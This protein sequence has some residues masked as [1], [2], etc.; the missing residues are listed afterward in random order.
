MNLRFAIAM[1]TVSFCNATHAMD[2]DDSKS[3]SFHS[4]LT[5]GLKRDSKL[6]EYPAQIRALDQLTLDR[7]TDP[8]DRGCIRFFR[9]NI[10][11]QISLLSQK[12]IEVAPM[13]RQARMAAI[14]LELATPRK[15]Y[16]DVVSF[17]HDVVTQNDPSLG[18]IPVE[19][20]LAALTESHEFLQKAP[21]QDQ[22]VML[23]TVHGTLAGNAQSAEEALPHWRAVVDIHPTAETRNALINS[24]L[25]VA[26]K[27][28]AQ[29]TELCREAQKN[30][31]IITPK[32]LNQRNPNFRF[33]TLLSAELC[34]LNG[35]FDQ[36]LK[37]VHPLRKDPC[38]QMY[39]A[40]AYLFKKNYP[41]GF[42]A[43]ASLCTS[44][45]PPR[46]LLDVYERSR[47]REAITPLLRNGAM[48]HVADDALDKKSK[49]IIAQFGDKITKAEC[50]LHGA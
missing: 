29:R 46:E 12:L 18:E 9:P 39:A 11:H 10:E 17:Y 49:T 14:D 45:L 48:A 5:F 22:L 43:V 2:A 1:A 23:H 42:K 25:V 6:P 36:T 30:L 33:H 44:T 27:K 50:T 24:L 28:P 7:V 13:N 8:D 32:V 4:M 40:A 38:A 21:D 19:E 3:S 41:E 37:L 26:H 16:A 47:C 15:V 35:D 34:N 31:A 20:R